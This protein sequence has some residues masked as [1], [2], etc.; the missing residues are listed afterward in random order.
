MYSSNSVVAQMGNNWC[1]GRH[2][3]VNFNTTPPSPFL[4]AIS[5]TNIGQTTS[6]KNITV[7]PVTVSDCAGNLWFYSAGITV[8]NRYHAP[9][10]NGMLGLNKYG[11]A[12]F[13]MAIPKPGDDSAFYLLIMPSYGYYYTL[14][15]MRLDSGRGDVAFQPKVLE[16]TGSYNW[17]QLTGLYIKHINDTDYW[18]V[19]RPGYDIFKSF[20][21]TKDSITSKAVP[22]NGVVKGLDFTLRLRAT[23]DGLNILVPN[24]VVN[25]NYGLLQSYKFDRKTGKLSKPTDL[26]KRVW[27]QNRFDWVLYPELS[28]NDSIVYYGYVD[29]TSGKASSKDKIFICQ[30]QRFASNPTKTIKYIDTLSVGPG[31]ASLAGIKLGP[32]NKLYYVQN[33]SKINVIHYPD[34]IGTNC[35]IQ[36]NYIDIY[37]AWN[38]INMPCM[39]FPIKRINN[40][41]VISGANGCGYDTVTFSADADSGF[42][43]YN[44][45]FGD[46]DS[47]VGKSVVHQYRKAGS[48]YVKLGCELGNCG[49]IQWVGDSVSIKFKPNIS[50]TD[51]TYY[52]C[53]KYNIETK[54]NYKYS[55]TISLHLG[56]KDTIL[57]VNNTDTVNTFIYKQ[58]LDTNG[59]YI[60]YAA[61]KNQ[62]CYDSVALLKHIVN[63]HP[64]LIL[65]FTPN[66]L[67][68]CGNSTITLTDSSGMDSIIQQRKWT[69]E[70][71]IAIG[72]NIKEYDTV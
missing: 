8:W 60:Y 22:S 48:Y 49:Y 24:T 57:Y 9:M 10:P 33:I 14:V 20:L 40:H 55:D 63:I 52:T 23:R 11:S 6:N 26:I 42:K 41:F 34:I 36:H 32:D 39:D 51:T 50:L 27:L 16:D 28:A 72:T 13:S 25:S 31:S 64:K 37:P 4:S 19:V 58:V 67:Q 71:P 15:D 54:L 43:S 3:G 45:Y 68:S 44:W 53:G 56:N 69:I 38:G 5:D 21:V 18:I 2:G 7:N 65:N 47:A 61:A 1:I 46:G 70:F 29:N 35:K 59:T 62:N 30:L 66:Y 17:G 12:T